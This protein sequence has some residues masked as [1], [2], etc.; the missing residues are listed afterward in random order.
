MSQLSIKGRNR[1][2]KL[3]AGMFII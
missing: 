1:V 2:L 3:N